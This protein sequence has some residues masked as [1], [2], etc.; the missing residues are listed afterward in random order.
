MQFSHKS[1][2]SGDWL[3]GACGQLEFCIVITQ[4]LHMYWEP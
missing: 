4:Q 1:T 3:A 2:V